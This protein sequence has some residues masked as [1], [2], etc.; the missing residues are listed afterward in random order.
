[1]KVKKKIILFKDFATCCH[2]GKNFNWVW[3]R[4][5]TLSFQFVSKTG[6]EVVFQCRDE[7]P[8]RARVQWVR[9]NNRPLPPGTR[10]NNGRLEIPNILMEH[11]G[12]YVC[13]A[14]G[15][16]KSAP[17]STVSVQLT[18]EKC[19]SLN[20]LIAFFKFLT[21]WVCPRNAAWNRFK[22]IPKNRK[23]RFGLVPHIDREFF[24]TGIKN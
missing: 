12:E 14:V 4:K 16:P 9:R 2:M 15:Y 7:G 18:V 8:I 13:E 22:F 21:K 19:K 24:G 11:G 20:N 3:K 5:L 1:M 6:R 17:G 23:I 10:D